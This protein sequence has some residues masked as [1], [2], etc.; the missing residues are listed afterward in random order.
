ME[1]DV[2]VW[3]TQLA[4]GERR[5]LPLAPG[6]HA[7]VHVARGSVS[8]NGTPLREGDG[9]GVSNEESLTLRGR[10]RG[11]GPGFRPEIG[12]WSE[13]MKEAETKERLPPRG[14]S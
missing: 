10:R 12:R 2:G 6:R 11:R 14:R 9:A 13:R 7:W 8:V 4:K 3:M 5:E 1:Q